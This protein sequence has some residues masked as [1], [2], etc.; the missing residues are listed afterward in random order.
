[1]IYHEQ[2]KKLNQ[3]S[4]ERRLE[5]FMIKN[6]WEQLEGI[7]KNVLKLETGIIGKNEDVLSQQTL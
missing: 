2:L 7:K 5:R 6:T 3:Y 4:L 1:M